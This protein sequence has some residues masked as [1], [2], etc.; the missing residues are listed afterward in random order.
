ML[1]GWSL[2]FYW[3][4]W[5][6]WWRKTESK[7]G[8][9]FCSKLEDEHCCIWG[10]IEFQDLKLDSFNFFM[11]LFK[12]FPSVNI[13]KGHWDKFKISIFFTKTHKYLDGFENIL[14]LW[15]FNLEVPWTSACPWLIPVS[16][17]SFSFGSFPSF[18]PPQGDGSSSL[19]HLT[20]WWCHTVSTFQDQEWLFPYYQLNLRDQGEFLH[21]K[22]WERL[23][24]E[25]WSPRNTLA[26]SALDWLSNLT[27]SSQIQD[28]DL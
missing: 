10:E 5:N 17:L 27:I 13:V 14:E 22:G 26:P 7:A 24:R 6:L 8:I 16:T 20:S 2:E 18:S 4:K 28:F 25:I 11:C 1:Q 15:L 9:S 19:A 3:N 12:S 23:S 21:G